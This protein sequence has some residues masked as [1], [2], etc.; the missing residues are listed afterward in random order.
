MPKKNSG[1]VD[2]PASVE[3]VQ[4]FVDANRQKFEKCLWG[5]KEQF[6][7]LRQAERSLRCIY[8]IYSRGEMQ[9]GEE[10]KASRKIRLKFNEHNE[11]AKR[12]EASLFDVPDIVGITVVVPNPS[13]I[14]VVASA[15]D[16]LIDKG[17]LVA[18]KLG[19]KPVKGA[20]IQSV[21][22]RPIESG[23]YYA[24]HYNV[25][26]DV[27]SSAAP[28]C[29]I[30]IKT[31]LHDA[32]GAKTHDLT[33]KPNGKIG[34]ELLTSFELL[35]NN[36]ANL[37]QQS[38]VLRQS[39]L[40]NSAVREAKRRH[41]Q[42]CVLEMTTRKRIE[43]VIDPAAKIAFVKH[44]DD[45]IGMSDET[46][47]DT[48]KQ[49]AKKLSALYIKDPAAVSASLCLLAAMVQRNP[50]I[51]KALESLAAREQDATDDLA[52]LHIRF[53]GALAAFA[54]GDVPRAI[55]IAEACLGDARR[56]RA[57]GSH[58]TNRLDNILLSICSD[59]A[60]Y[61][62]DLVGSHEAEKRKSAVRAV[63][64]AKDCAKLY[65]IVGIPIAG[66]DAAKDD[67]IAALR[68]P[69]DSL[70]IFFVLD[71][72]AYVRIQTSST[73]A[74]LRETLKKLE[75]LH[76]HVPDGGE[77]AAKLAIDYHEYCWRQRL[78]DLEGTG[79]S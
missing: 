13:D 30:Q 71:N 38:D 6:K 8:K 23:G 17:D 41:V 12:A 58:D 54:I 55:D 76:E 24:C 32:W 16:R 63:Q 66:L 61:H 46:S 77:Q 27:M 1:C 7:E 53:Q 45:I 68:D 69:T 62:A 28:I 9:D 3:D 20:T 52:A 75:F 2:V 37:D 59:L 29:E 26:L 51:D 60:Y 18:I 49:I 72:E 35:G 73:I 56:W 25:R 11:N 64:I 79:F 57:D 21:H 44:L 65:S 74:E 31:L 4:A 22:G 33:Y 14:S 39:I 36:L 67:I 50:Y 34:A 40:R 5:I 70:R 42:T 48:A 43:A 19:G 10:L 78:A 15:L 47:D